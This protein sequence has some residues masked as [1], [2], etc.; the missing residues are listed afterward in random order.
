MF[1]RTSKTKIYRIT[2]TNIETFKYH[3]IQKFVKMDLNNYKSVEE[4]DFDTL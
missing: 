1:L 3:I 2:R 4:K